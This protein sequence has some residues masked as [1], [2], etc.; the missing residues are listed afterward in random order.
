V[1][2]S[3]ALCFESVDLTLNEYAVYLK[4]GCRE[5][6]PLYLFDKKFTETCSGLRDEFATP[7]YFDEDLFQILGRKR[8][9]HRWII[10]GP[11]RSGSTFHIDPNS[12]ACH[13]LPKLTSSKCM[14]RCH[15]WCKEVDSFPAWHVATR[16]ICEPGSV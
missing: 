3:V 4:S 13:P 2:D 1:I 11:T 7:S 5:E 9:D 6:A 8:P 14:E 15:Y 16:R 10:I 12:S